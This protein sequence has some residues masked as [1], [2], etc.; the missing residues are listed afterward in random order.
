MHSGVHA[1]S[2]YDESVQDDCTGRVSLDLLTGLS[3]NYHII[4]TAS[5]ERM[6]IVAKPILHASTSFSATRN[7]G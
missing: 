4:S 1:G 6:R 3:I 5:I 2:A 7:E